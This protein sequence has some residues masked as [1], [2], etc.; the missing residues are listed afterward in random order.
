WFDPPEFPAGWELSAEFSDLRQRARKLIDDDF[1]AATCWGWKDP[2]TCLTLPFWKQ[3]LPPL[4]YVIC[5][6]NRT[7]VAKSLEH[8]MPIEKGMNLWHQYTTAALEHSAG[9]PRM[10]IFYEDLMENWPEHSQRLAQIVSAPGTPAAA[11]LDEIR[12]TVTNELR[13]HRA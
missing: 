4:F 9:Q 2:R 10:F 1:G 5:L 12:G 7:D 13:H 6:R 11:A 3:V 8:A